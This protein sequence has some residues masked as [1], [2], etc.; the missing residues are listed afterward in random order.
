MCTRGDGTS[1]LRCTRT[2]RQIHYGKPQGFLKTAVERFCERSLWTSLLF[3][4]WCILQLQKMSD[5][6]ITLAIGVLIW[7]S[8]A[9]HSF[10][11]N[12]LPS[13]YLLWSPRGGH[14]SWRKIMPCYIP[15]ESLERGGWR[16]AS[17]CLEGLT[18]RTG[19]S[20]SQSSPA[21][22]QFS[23]VL[24]ESCSHFHFRFGLTVLFTLLGRFSLLQPHWLILTWQSFIT[25]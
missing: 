8:N 4:T 18:Y 17:K 23:V 16:K 10:W 21:I 9:E 7:H 13:L 11:P 15:E 14:G 20:P 22:G 2:K 12:F 19:S 3:K 5:S 6:C 24:L 25:K 1:W